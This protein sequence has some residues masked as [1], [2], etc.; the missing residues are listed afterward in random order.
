MKRILTALALI[1][2]SAFI[3]LEVLAACGSY[4]QPEGPDTFSGGPCPNTFSKTAHWHLFFTDGHETHDVQVKENGRCFGGTILTCYP[5][6]DTP[7]WVE[8]TIGK[9][10]QV[11]HDP[12]ID[13]NT[14]QCIYNSPTTQNHFYTYNCRAQCMGETDY[15]NYSTGCIGDSPPTAVLAG[16]LPR[17]Q[18]TALTTIRITMKKHARVSETRES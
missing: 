1:V 2:V 10:N 3:T 12:D 18:L 5:G 16:D 4:F 15:I 14:S 7:M 13:L 8:T 11:T 9:W 17:L 6:Y